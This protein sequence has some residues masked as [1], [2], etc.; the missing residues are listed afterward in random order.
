MYR[1]VSLATLALSAAIF[2][3]ATATACAPSDVVSGTGKINAI[4]AAE[5][6]VNVTH[7][8]IPALDWPGMT[9]DFRVADTAMLEGIDVG[10][11]ITFRLRKGDDGVYEI[12]S[13]SLSMD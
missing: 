10:D 1:P 6:K 3:F 4:M 8:P 7:E 9:M 12:E 11:T 13:L 2:V 5:G